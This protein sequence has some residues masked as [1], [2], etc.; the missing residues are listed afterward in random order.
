[1]PKERIAIIGIGC[2]FPGGVNDAESFWKLLVEGREA[3]CEVPADRWNVER[4]YDP[5]AG[6]RG[7]IDRQA[8][9]IPRSDRPIR[10]AVF[11]DFAAGSA[12]RRSAAAACCWRRH[13]RRSRMPGM[14]LDLE[15]RDRHRR[16]RRHFPQRLSGH[17]G[18]A[19][20]TTPGS[21]PHSPTGSA[22][23]IAANR[24]SYCLNLRGPSVAMDTACSSALT[25]V[26][27][28]CEHIWAGRG[29]SGARGRRDGDD[30]ARRVHRLFAGVDAFARRALQGVRCG[31]ERFRAGRRRGHGAA[32]AALPSDRRRRSDPGRD[33]R[34]V[35]E[36]G[37]PHQRHFA[38]EPRSA[39]AAGA[40]RVPDA[41]VARR[42]SA[43]S[44]RTA[45][46]PR[47]AIRS[48]RTRSRRRFAAIVRRTRRC[49]S[50]R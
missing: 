30:H 10:S 6:H 44:K 27:A 35:A 32:E 3:V 22:H 15:K 21:A 18:H 47:S 31:G 5:G 45:P 2:R 11:R 34:H 8:R 37:R 36:S 40:G 13:G 9:R 20:S 23:S 17:P 29:D 14:V 48:K 19:R 50:A 26:H 4:F 7:K 16:L 42:R 1:M 46:A 38:A 24:I 49:R 39:G 28:A 41:G 25:A 43:S 33:P 12:L